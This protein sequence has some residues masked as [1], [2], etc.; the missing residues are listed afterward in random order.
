MILDDTGHDS[1]VEPVDVHDVDVDVYAL[2]ATRTDL[3]PRLNG[4]DIYHCFLEHSPAHEAL[5]PAFL[6]PSVM[7]ALSFSISLKLPGIFSRH[8]DTLVASCTQLRCLSIYDSTYI[9]TY[10]KNGSV[11]KAGRW[12]A[13]A[14][15]MLSEAAYI[16]EIHLD[17]PLQYTDLV[18]LSTVPSLVKLNVQ[19]VISVPDILRSLPKGAFARLINL[20][21]R[22]DTSGARLTLHLL[23]F[24]A[25][26][27]FA[28]CRLYIDADIS[29]DTACIVLRQVSSHTS[30]RSISVDLFKLL[31]IASTLSETTAMLGA[32]RPSDQLRLL[33]LSSLYNG[34]KTRLPL[35]VMHFKTVCSLYPR[36]ERW[37]WHFPSYP[38]PFRLSLDALLRLLQPYPQ[39]VWLPVMIDSPDVPPVEV[40][41]RFGSRDDGNPLDIAVTKEADTAE[42]RAALSDL[43]PRAN[44]PRGF[45]S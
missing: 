31:N 23:T 15:D 20:E 36:L 9:G 25:Q 16:Q 12:A 43:F 27:G 39:L 44:V 45:I 10:D 29:L 1:M 4:L 26:A 30:L 19:S 6:R 17:I 37:A 2:W 34:G 41:T 8:R 42:L 40:R 3:F 5:L 33:T 35:D 22:D 38:P 13:L 7:H 18:R 14:R 11:E 24:E 32:L 21:L 28:S